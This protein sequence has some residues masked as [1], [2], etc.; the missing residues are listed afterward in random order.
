MASLVA[1]IND[2]GSVTTNSIVLYSSNL[3]LLKGIQQLC[4]TLNYKVSKIKKRKD[5]NVYL[6]RIKEID[7]FYLDYLKLVKRYPVTKLIERKERVLKIRELIKNRTTR[8][9]GEIEKLIINALKDGDKT[10]Y[11]LCEA[12]R[13][14]SS[15]LHPYLRQLIGNNKIK[16]LKAKNVK[17][18]FLY[19]IK[20]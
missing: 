2:E 18:K 13:L 19:K 6:F 10:I 4:N 20:C 1:F 11:D 9:V 15:T 5:K 7:K 16:R 17:A 12:L 8:S 3:K 14:T